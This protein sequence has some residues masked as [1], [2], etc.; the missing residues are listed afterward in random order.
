M[1]RTLLIALGVILVL[2]AAL[3]Y[4]I[5]FALTTGSQDLVF[6]LGANEVIIRLANLALLLLILLPLGLGLAWAL[7]LPA[8]LGAV[9]GR[10]RRERGLEALELALLAA[11][12]GDGRGARREAKRA[13]A[14]L[15][16][17]VA[18]RLIAAQAAE[19]MGDLV[20]AESQYAAMLAEPA[21]MLVGRRGLSAAAL[22][23]RDFETAILHAREAF[24]SQPDMRWAFD[25][26]FDALVRS[27]KW[28]EALET[29]ADGAR[30][31]HLPEAAVRRR[32]AVLLCAQAAELEHAEPQRA[33][34]LAEQAA[35]LSPAFA[36][37]AALAARLLTSAG[38]TWR[39]ASL[40]E[41]AW[42]ANPH[43]ALALAYRDVKTDETPLQRAKRLT[44]LAEMNPNHRESRILAAEQA[45]ALG[46][47]GAAEAQLAPLLA[48]DKDPSARLCGLL[49]HVAQAL[50]KPEEAR[51]W[52]DRAQRAADEPDWSDLDPEGPAFAYTAE[53][54]ARLVY[55]FGDTGA[56][57][58][59]RHERFERARVAIPALALLSD[60]S[61]PAA[62]VSSA[63]G[64]PASAPTRA[65][66][67]LAAPDTPER[68]SPQPLQPDDPGPDDPAAGPGGPRRSRGW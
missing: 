9:G 61:A 38:K 3:L 14:L 63:A 51:R 53:D 34:E 42:A 56:L 21:T 67:A 13:E 1:R 8:R 41:D 33:R 44:G 37:G 31:R 39:A 36:P 55:S 59:P 46:L 17:P 20:G 45:L 10:R 60:E 25:L 52:L 48:L 66:P 58:H 50:D 27:N 7:R 18:A 29:L 65:R 57:I 43:P 6:R 5:I 26:L 35:S 19:Q 23:R 62:P 22:A 12:I 32:R 49:A 11:A 54:W 2:L 68:R 47:G 4:A 24:A 40:I 15:D 28:Q 16:R 64:E 30:R